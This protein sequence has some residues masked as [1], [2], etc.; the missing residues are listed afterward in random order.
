MA[1]LAVDDASSDGTGRIAARL[2]AEE[3][4][5]SA[6]HRRGP[7]GLGG[8]LSEGL[9]AARRRGFDVVATMDGDLSHDPARLPALLDAAE[10]AQ[11]VIGSRY[12]PGGR[13]VNWSSRR[14]LLSLSAN[15]FVRLLFSLPVRDCTSNFR[16][17]RGHV[18]DAVPWDRVYSTGYAFLVELLVRALRA[19][20]ARAIEVPIEFRERAGGCSKL[21]LRE[22]AHGLRHLPRLRL[23]IA[24]RRT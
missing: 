23:E 14:R 2:A 22:A 4:R 7:R 9:R 17:Y 13:I 6:L 10:S 20:G 5:F 8:A 16:V 11:V 3:P 12:V 15:R 21:G 19:D 24:R 18:L 1:V